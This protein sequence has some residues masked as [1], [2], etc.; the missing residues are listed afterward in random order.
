MCHHQ[1]HYQHIL[2]SSSSVQHE[3][4]LVSSYVNA[5]LGL[6]VYGSWSSCLNEL[7]SKLIDLSSQIRRF[8]LGVG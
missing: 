1:S 6:S 3:M 8:I 5:K 2:S 7:G 4:I